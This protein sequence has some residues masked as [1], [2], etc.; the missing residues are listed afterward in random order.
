MRVAARRRAGNTGKRVKRARGRQ[1]GAYSREIG[2]ASRRVAFSPALLLKPVKHKLP[3]RHPQSPARRRSGVICVCPLEEPLL[4]VMEE[5]H[6]LSFRTF[7]IETVDK[8]CPWSTD[9][10]L[11]STGIFVEIA[12]NTLYESKLYIFLLCQKSLD[13]KIMFHV[14]FIP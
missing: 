7:R 12:N 6:L 2:V 4:I 10:V 8:M 14:N 3:P 13:I 9:A 5:S 11:S 1:R